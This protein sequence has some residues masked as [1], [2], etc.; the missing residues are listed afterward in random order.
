MF[1][2]VLRIINFGVSQIFHNQK[3]SLT[4]K[5]FKNH[6]SRACINLTFDFN[7]FSPEIC[8]WKFSNSESTK[9]PNFLFI[10]SSTILDN[11]KRGILAESK[12]LVA[13]RN[14]RQDEKRVGCIGKASSTCTTTG[15]DVGKRFHGAERW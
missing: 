6:C 4:S 7:Y 11:R 14:K 13:R 3:C 2:F 10:Y 8:K 9:L 5:R 12:F 1:L 15:G